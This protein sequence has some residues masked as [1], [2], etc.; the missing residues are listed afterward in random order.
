[1]KSSIVSVMIVIGIMGAAGLMI[2]SRA[3]AETEMPALVKDG[4]FACAGCHN[5]DTKKVGPAWRDVSKFYNGKM[6]KTATGKTLQEV[7]GGKSAEDFLVEKISK[8]G[9]G[10]WMPMPMSPVDPSGAKQAQIREIAQWIL[11]LEK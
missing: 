10:N 3:V 4:G 7:T 5:V 8:G 6:D 11:N 2:A 9:K 1:M